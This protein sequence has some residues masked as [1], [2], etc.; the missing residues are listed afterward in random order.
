[1]IVTRNEKRNTVSI[2]DARLIFKNFSGK[3][4]RYNPKGKRNFCLYLSEEAVEDFESDGWNVKHFTPNENYPD[5]NELEGY[6]KVNVNF[7]ERGIPPRIVLISSKG[8]TTLS[9]E[10]INIL[11]WCEAEN[12]DLTIR[13]YDWEINGDTGRTAYLTAI[14]VTIVEDELDKK[15]SDIPDSAQSSIFQSEDD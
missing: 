13:P 11:D 15:Y 9:E 3:E 4:G 7:S 8:K 14:Y 10:D 5:S 12:I 2:E 1:M 6:L